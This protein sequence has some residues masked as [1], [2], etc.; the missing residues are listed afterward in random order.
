[1]PFRP[2]PREIEK[3]IERRGPLYRSIGLLFPHGIETTS[4][5]KFPDRAIPLQ[6]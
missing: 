3:I 2:G 6:A 4:A 1:L 5:A